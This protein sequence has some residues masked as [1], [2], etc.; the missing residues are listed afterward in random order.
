MHEKDG[1]P[2]R[3]RA[4]S[5]VAVCETFARGTGRAISVV[6][7]QSPL[8]QKQQ[9]HENHDAATATNARLPDLTKQF[10][11]SH[12]DATDRRRKRAYS[13]RRG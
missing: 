8:S 4:N 12:C 6:D 3:E 7:L 9:P 2:P 10:K 11:M 1:L 13:L 5:S